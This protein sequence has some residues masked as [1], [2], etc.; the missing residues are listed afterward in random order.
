[1]SSFD[2][3][4]RF[5]TR[6]L[7]F[8]TSFLLEAIVTPGIFSMLED[9]YGPY[10]FH[11]PRSVVRELEVLSSSDKGELARRAGLVLRYIEESGFN[12]VPSVSN[13]ADEDI[14][15]LSLGGDYVVATLDSRLRRLLSDKGIRVLVLKDGYP[16]IV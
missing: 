4:S 7:L 10:S 13:V 11:I 5:R 14:L 8:D 6:G 12:I 2:D 15:Q 3:V 1:M 16:K 9:L